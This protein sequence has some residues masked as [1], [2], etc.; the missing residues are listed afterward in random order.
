MEVDQLTFKTLGERAILISWEEIIE[1]DILKEILQCKKIIQENYIKSNVEVNNTYNSLLINY[2]LGIE[3]TYD[4]ISVLKKLLLNINFDQKMKVNTYILPVCYE[5]EFALDLEEICQ[6]KDLSSEEFIKLH[7]SSIY[8]LYFIGFL[9]G[10]LYLGGLPK[11]LQIPRKKTPRLHVKK[12]AV[13][14]GEK[15]TGIYPQNSAGG[16]QLIGNC[17]LT[18]F[19]SSQTSPSPFLPGDEVRFKSISK[20]EHQETLR[21]VEMGAYKIENIKG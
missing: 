2:G 20:N 19:D 18:L 15:Q 5:E 3:N 14:I 9:P 13:G 12:G 10:F 11:T 21:Q 4:E 8:T 1:K 17:P 7:T 16:W 6:D